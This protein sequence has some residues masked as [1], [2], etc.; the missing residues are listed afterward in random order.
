M[1]GITGGPPIIEGKSSQKPRSF[2]WIDFFFF[3]LN[4][5]GL[6]EGSV[7]YTARHG[8][9]EFFFNE[10]KLTNQAT[11]SRVLILDL[12]EDEDDEEEEEDDGESGFEEGEVEEGDGEVGDDEE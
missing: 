11:F 10:M 1:N 2:C 8:R 4:Q 7:Y 12:E 3:V 5:L 9:F 6:E